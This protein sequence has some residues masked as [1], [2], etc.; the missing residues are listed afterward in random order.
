MAQD[1]EDIKKLA[2]ARETAVTQRRQLADALGDRGG[3]TENM[4]DAFVAVQALIEAI[5]RAI[6]DERNIE[7][8]RPR[9]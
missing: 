3:P 7:N 2:T 6:T 5:D 4:R 8:T 1:N 9:S